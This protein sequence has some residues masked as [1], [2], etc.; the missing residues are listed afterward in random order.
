MPTVYTLHR[1]PGQKP[2][3]PPR[4]RDAAPAPVVRG[5]LS[6]KQKAV[7]CQLAATAAAHH[8]ITGSRAVEAWRR[9]QVRD[10]FGLA[11][12]TLATQEHYADIKSH[13]EALGGNAGEAFE[14]ARKGLDNQRRIARW[15]LDKA[16][17][18][19]NLALNYAAAICKTQYRTALEDASTKQLWALVYTIRNRA[20]AKRRKLTAAEPQPSPVAPDPEPDADNI[21]Y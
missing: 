3:G 6:N 17:R 20:S 15:N 16:L 1:H 9:D 8:G 14:S 11:S 2:S 4:R 19:A 12:L 13:F 10:R 21:P 18:E 5:S 7:L